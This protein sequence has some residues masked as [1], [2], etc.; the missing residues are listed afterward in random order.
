MARRGEMEVVVATVTTSEIWYGG[1][2]EFISKE[3]EADANARLIAAAPALKEALDNAT[4][5]LE[6]CLTHFGKY[7]PEA[8]RIG[9]AKVIHEARALLARIEGHS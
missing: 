3:T 6:T 2:G 9:R 7:M 8:D 1:V 5:S 4:A